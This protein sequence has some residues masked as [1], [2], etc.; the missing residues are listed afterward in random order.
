[1]ILIKFQHLNEFPKDFIGNGDH[2]TSPS[3]AASPTRPT[4]RVWRPFPPDRRLLPSHPG[5]QT[6]TCKESAFR[7]REQDL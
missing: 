7:N 4:F 1:M 2:G 6:R 5:M 3:R